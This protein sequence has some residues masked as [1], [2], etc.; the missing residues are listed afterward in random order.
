MEIDERNGLV[1]KLLED[2][3]TLSDIQKLLQSEYGVNLTYMDLR[4]IVSEIEVNWE[5][6]EPEPEEDPEDDAEAEPEA[7]PTPGDTVVN[8]SPVVRP[9]A[10]FSGDVTFKSGIKAEWHLD[11]MGRLGLN[12]ANED[13]RPTEE[14]FAEFQAELQRQLQGRM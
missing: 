1:A 11:Q 9:G 10:I 6:V 14:D 3:E 7:E 5:K 8:V 4:L 13:D 2:G 12:P